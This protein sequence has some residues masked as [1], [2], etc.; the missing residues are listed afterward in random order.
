MNLYDGKLGIFGAVRDYSTNVG[1]RVNC[2]KV[3][4]S[5]YHQKVSGKWKMDLPA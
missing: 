1:E 4:K 5:Y 2:R 3:G